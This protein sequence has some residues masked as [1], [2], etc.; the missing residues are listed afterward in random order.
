MG[1]LNF[2]LKFFM[3]VKSLLL[4]RIFSAEVAQRIIFEWHRSFGVLVYYATREVIS[5]L[6]SIPGNPGTNFQEF[7]QILEL[8]HLFCIFFQAAAYTIYL[9]AAFAEDLA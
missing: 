3:F 5:V 1:S 6:E 9:G 8:G 4:F 7:C 2:L